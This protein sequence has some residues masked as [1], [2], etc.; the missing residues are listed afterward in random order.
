MKALVY[1][2]PGKINF[3]DKP[4]PKIEN[5]TDCIVRITTTTICG[6]DLHIMKGDVPTV[7]PGRILGHEGVGI[8]EAIGDGISTFHVNDKVL[9]SCISSCGKCHFCKRQMYSHCDVGGW[10]LGHKIDGTQAEYVRIPFADTSL[11]PIPLKV[12]EEAMAMFSD[13]LPTGFET[14]VLKGQIK[15]GDTVA[16]VGAGPIG[17]ATLLTAQ[18]Y[19]PSEVIMIDLRRRAHDELVGNTKTHECRRCL[20]VRGGHGHAVVRQLPVDESR[21]TYRRRAGATK[22][23]TR[24]LVTVTESAVGSTHLPRRR[25]RGEPGR[26]CVW[27]A[28]LPPHPPAG[29]AAIRAA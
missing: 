4:Y 5:P 29:G 27:G 6:T 19:S 18:F 15:L 13:I 1:H 2:G 14:G 22:T 25:A 28:S 8:I 12:D 23:V 26:H 11:H 9:I 21:A 7:E 3:E 10:L 24:C 16:I 20:D 17:L